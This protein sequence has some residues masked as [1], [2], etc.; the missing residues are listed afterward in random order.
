MHQ[1]YSIYDNIDKSD[2][3]FKI[4]NSNMMKNLEKINLSQKE[5]SNAFND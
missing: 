4:T 3:D 2:K 5:K 1:G